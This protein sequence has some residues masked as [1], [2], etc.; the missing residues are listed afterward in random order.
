[1]HTE[2]PKKIVFIVSRSDTIG[3]SLVHVRDMAL[4]L[5]QKGIDG[6]ILVG[7]TGP[8]T[9]QL[10]KL[11]IPYTPLQ[12]L[13]NQIHPVHA[14]NSYRELHQ[15]IKALN[16]G[17]ISTHSASARFLGGYVAKSLK[18][19]IISTAHGW[20]CSD[21]RPLLSR[22]FAEFMERW[23]VK[24]SDLVITVS[25]YDRLIGYKRLG[26]PK[27]KLMTIHNGMYDIDPS[28]LAI[29][30]NKGTVNITMIARMDR[31]KNHSLLL[32]ALAQLD[33]YHL[34]LVG[35]GPFMA[36]LKAM[37]ADLNIDAHTTFW[38][39]LDDVAPVLANS[40]LFTLISN[41][42]GFPRS[43]LEAMRA[44]LPV[45]ISDA[46]GA[47]EAVDEGVTGLISRSDDPK[48][49]ADLFR[50]LIDDPS[51]RKKMGE[52]GRKRFENRYLFETMF[53]KTQTV[54]EQYLQV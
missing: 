20:S 7:N 24:R 43:T 6:H 2:A 48:E 26:I 52:A 12:Y 10:D 31:Q 53:Q 16:P 33:G 8:F 37:T 25:E 54:Y 40:Q 51:L 49:L 27:S 3:G 30:G 38:G 47:A 34:H 21:G 39:R 23:A 14:Y 19:P 35:D 36:N 41:W 32:R 13:S 4:S 50:K 17:L 44:G 1:M 9:H 45:V 18:I 11:G 42:E 28:Q 22:K 5:K 46:G 29:P 15:A